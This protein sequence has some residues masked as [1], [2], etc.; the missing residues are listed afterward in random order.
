MALHGS[1]CRSG[2]LAFDPAPIEEAGNETLTLVMAVIPVAFAV[3]ATAEISLAI[4]LTAVWIGVRCRG[5]ALRGR[6][7]VAGKGCLPA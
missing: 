4:G 5:K 6:G 3:V 1:Q 2:L 7:Q